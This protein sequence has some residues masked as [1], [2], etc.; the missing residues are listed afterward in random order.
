MSSVLS[1]ALQELRAWLWL[2]K[3]DLR[4]SLNA[5]E[6]EDVLLECFIKNKSGNVSYK[7]NGILK[8]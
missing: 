7:Q 2:K 1:N 5:I 6:I 4:L 3:K 8:S